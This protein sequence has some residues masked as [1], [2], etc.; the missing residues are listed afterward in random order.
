MNTQWSIHRRSA[1]LLVTS[2]MLTSCSGASERS[3]TWQELHDSQFVPVGEFLSI[4]NGMQLN[5]VNAILGSAVRH[6]FTVLDNG[7]IWTLIRC[8]IDTGENQAY[9][10]YQL[11]FSDDILLK[12][13]GW[14]RMEREKYPYRGTTATR[15]RPW[16]IEDMKYVKKAIKAPA[17]THE[18]IRAKIKHSRETM[19]KHKGEGNIPQFIG[20]LFALAFRAKAKAGYLVNEKLR[21]TFDGCKASIGMTSN[22][23]EA[24]YGRP[25]HSFTTEKGDAARVYGNDRYLGNAVDSFLV[26]SYVAVLFDPEGRVVAVYSDGFFCNDWYPGLPAWRRDR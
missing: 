25:L 9:I 16:D 20:R 22:E 5:E 15:L 3:E 10:Y 17:I 18:Q 11:L 4:T 13:I 8:F 26:F 2:L 14:I 12:T 6:H 1:L 23:V 7:H 19:R 24:L 21:Q